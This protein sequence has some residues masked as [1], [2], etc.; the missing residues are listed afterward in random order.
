[1]SGTPIRSV[2]FIEA[3]ALVKLVIDSIRDRRQFRLENI[4]GLLFGNKILIGG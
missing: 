3:V 2:V 4:D 1:M